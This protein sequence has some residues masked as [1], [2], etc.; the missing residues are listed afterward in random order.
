MDFGPIRRVL[1]L[2]F[3]KTGGNLSLRAY[4]FHAWELWICDNI[5]SI[6]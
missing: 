1:F 2:V 5:A 6:W 4:L 3:F